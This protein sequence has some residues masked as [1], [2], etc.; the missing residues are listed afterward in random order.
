MSRLRPR[1]RVGDLARAA[2]RVDRIANRAIRGWPAVTPRRVRRLGRKLEAAVPGVQV[3]T[4]YSRAHRE[5][6]KFLIDGQDIRD[7][8]PVI[9]SQPPGSAAFAA[10]MLRMR[11]TV[12]VRRARHQAV[13]RCVAGHPRQPLF[14]RT[15]ARRRRSPAATRAGPPGDGG[16][17][18][19][20]PGEARRPD[21]TRP[22]S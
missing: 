19:P 12:A 4:C 9:K 15:S 21:L 13:S 7:L 14:R 20:A 2:L 3:V 22:Q 1:N 8:L 6:T 18:D 11:R 17:D 10:G 16:S 5:I